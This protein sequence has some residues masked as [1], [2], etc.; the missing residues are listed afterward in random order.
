MSALSRFDAWVRRNWGNPWLFWALV[1]AV[2]A[3][4]V[5]NRL[6]GGAF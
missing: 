2:A 6:L 1:T 4:V 5:V 3:G